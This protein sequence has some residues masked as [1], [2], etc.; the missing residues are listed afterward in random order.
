MMRKGD[1]M[2]S[3][4]QAQL[5][6]DFPTITFRSVGVVLGQGDYIDVIAKA[7]QDIPVSLVFNNAGYM[8]TGFFED[9][10]WSRHE[11][12]IG[13]NSTAAIALTHL[14]LTRMKARGLKGCIT[15]TSSPANIFPSPFSVLYGATKAMITHFATSLACEVKP[16]GIDVSV[17]HPSPVATHFYTGAHAMPTLHFFK[18]TAGGPDHVANV[19]LR[20]IGRNVVI[21]QGYYPFVLRL[22]LRLLEV[23]F[24]A[25]I[26]P[27]VVTTV[28][29]YKV[30]KAAQAEKKGKAQAAAPV[31]APSTPAV[32][33][34]A[35]PSKASAT[36]TPSRKRKGSVVA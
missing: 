36:P 8:V 23:M 26:I 11:A 29:D 25:E 21:D 14:F 27:H 34:S 20:G 24:L 16:D 15:F 6:A 30:L 13:C 28:A 5:Q 12:N 2:L 1:P 4:A 35:T 3:T 19:L 31:A 33:G 18:N 9:G 22:A 10:D 17:I 32:G 7:T